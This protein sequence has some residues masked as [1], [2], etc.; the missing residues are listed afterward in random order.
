[1]YEEGNNKGLR[2][3]SKGSPDPG[4]GRLPPHSGHFPDPGVSKKAKM[5]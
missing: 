4:L 2:R 5:G 1:M 3:G